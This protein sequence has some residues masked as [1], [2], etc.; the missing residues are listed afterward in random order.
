[1][2]PIGLSQLFFF[3]GEK[4]Q[5]LAEDASSPLF[6]ADAIKSLLGVD[7]VDQLGSDL[8]IYLNRTRKDAGTDELA[9]TIYTAEEQQQDIETCLGVAKESKATL[10]AQI[11]GIET[12]IT[13]EE[14]KIAKEG[15]GYARRR[16][17]LKINHARLTQQISDLEKQI[18]EACAGL[19]PFALV[20][21]L[22]E[23][24]RTQP[25]E[26]SGI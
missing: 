11:G 26:G 10:E 17:Q 5:G 20:P 18:H 16:E 15:G 22:C 7:L 24:L 3:D 8:K 25:D 4:I 23:Q 14:E 6:L 9:H 1:M 21:S 13:L 12:Q 2:I 19:F